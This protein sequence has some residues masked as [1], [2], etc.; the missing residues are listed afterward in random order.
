M[1]STISPTIQPARPRL[2][3]SHEHAA[4]LE[5]KRGLPSEVASE[6]GLVSHRQDTGTIGFLYQRNGQPTHVKW[7]AL[8]KSRM[9]QQPSGIAPYVWNLDSLIEASGR[10]DTLIITEGEFDTVAWAA[11]GAPYVIS[12]PNGSNSSKPGEGDILPETDTGFAYLWQAGRL[13]PDIAKFDRVVL[14]TDGDEPGVALREE[15]AVRIG[16]SKCFWFQYPAGSKDANDVLMQHGLEGLGRIMRNLL[17]IVPDRLASYSAI[18]P[19]PKG[20]SYSSGWPDLDPHLRFCPPELVVVTGTPGAGKSQWTLALAANLARLRG[21]R[22]AILQLEDHPDRNRLSLMAYVAAWSGQKNGI[23]ENAVEWIDRMFKVI[24]PPEREDADDC[25]S[26]SWLQDTITEAARRH[27]CKWVII[28]PWNEIEH[29]WSRNENETAYTN[30]ALRVLKRL[31]R[32]LQIIL[33]V[34]AHPTKG[35]AG[36]SIDDLSLY[37]ISGSAAWK[38]KADHGIVVYRADLASAETII[39]IDK[40]KDY[41]I[42]G[43]P[44][45]VRMEYV[46]QQGTYKFLGR[47]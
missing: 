46:Q 40:S 27:G 1:R 18:P 3:L 8:D 6:M 37:D 17:P 14:S 19:R 15:L 44:G 45:S 47:V 31:T 39:K 13:H 43:I 12:V 16:R 10:G 9:W 38:N 26:L 7:R 36:K 24:P 42:M 5:D 22:G 25:M 28:D 11:A 34:V 35:A 20:E 4:W 32:Q 41:D 33:I 29:V 21:L 23:D 2:Q 30:Q